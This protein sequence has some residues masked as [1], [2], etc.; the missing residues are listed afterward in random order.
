MPPGDAPEGLANDPI[1]A[2][3][4]LCRWRVVAASV[5]GTS[6]EKTG[7]PCQD[8]HRWDILPGDTLAVTVADGAGSAVLAEVGASLAAQT[9]VDVL[10][11]YRARQPWPTS[12]AAWQGLL[13][14]ALTAAREPIEAEARARAVSTRDF[15]TT[16]ILMVATPELV[17]TAQVGDGAAVVG[18]AAGHI[19]ALTTPQSGEYLNET[20]FLTSPEAL[21]TAQ[22]LVWHGAPASVAAFSDGL[23][24]LAL[25]M[26]EG[27]PHAP[28]FTPLFRF[29]AH[30]TDA[31]AAQE[32]L[33]TFLCSPRLRE[34]ADDDL[35][36]LIAVRH[37]A[38]SNPG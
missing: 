17:A 13:M 19:I 29:V 5:R 6:H 27:M 23:Q 36:L 18:D 11:L 1:P 3:A 8:A 33:A 7:Q 12:D 10:R 26:P 34:R 28:F 32:Q 21:H 22:V 20:T 14:D 38:Q 35:T 30:L 9:A 37:P 2:R 25:K 24:M 15:A 4:T 16:L 31:A